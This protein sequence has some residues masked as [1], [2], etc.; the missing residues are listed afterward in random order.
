LVLETGVS[1]YGCTQP[2]HAREDFREMVDHNCNAVLLAVSE[3]ECEHWWPAIKEIS[4]IAKKEFGLHVHVSTWGFGRVFGGEPISAFLQD[5]EDCRQIM[6][7][8]GRACAAACINTDFRR[9][10]L[11][12]VKTF[13]NDLTWEYL[14]QDEPHYAVSGLN[15][16][17]CRC[18]ECQQLFRGKYG[19]DMP[20]KLTDDVR[21]FRED[22]L[23]GLL[24]E[25]AS[26]VKAMDPNRRVITCLLPEGEQSGIGNWSKIASAKEIDVLSTDPYPYAFGK[27]AMRPYVTGVTTKALKL[28]KHY[29]KMSQIWVQ[30][31]AVP[32]DKTEEVKKTVKL[33]DELEVDG[34]KVDS[35]FCWSYRGT[36][37]TTLSCAK[38][39]LAW[40]LV[41]EA[42]GEILER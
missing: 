24:L 41:G 20:K 1:Y 16:W 18:P 3:F 23:A 22:T 32:A 35:I 39:D 5:H 42:F 25:A 7:E 4:R 36:N 29:G 33:I 19:Y 21:R 28:C 8:S 40:K 6:A 17:T 13:L 38:P 26:T 2:D 10:Y 30:L 15:E 31:F 14:F 9:Y 11:S 37:G 27:R 34:K 12:W